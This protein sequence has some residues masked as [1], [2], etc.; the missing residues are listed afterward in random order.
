[1]N[2]SPAEYKIIHTE[3]DDSSVVWKS[4]GMKYVSAF[5]RK[6]AM[7]SCVDGHG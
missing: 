7:W 1:M 4:I 3:W 5:T 2:A 6:Y